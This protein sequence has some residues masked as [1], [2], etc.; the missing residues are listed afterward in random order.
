M[1]GMKS[2][3]LKRLI[4]DKVMSKNRK[5]PG[6]FIRKVKQINR[7]SDLIPMF[8]FAGPFYLT[9]RSAVCIILI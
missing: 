4:K 7:Q 6:D 1:F 2:N 5:Q 3:S 8:S 9:V